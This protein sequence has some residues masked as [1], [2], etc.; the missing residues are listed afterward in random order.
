MSGRLVFVMHAHLPYVLGQGEWPHG[1]AWL[2]EAAVD[3]Y[4]PLLLALEGLAA[5]EVR[6]ALTLEFSPVLGEQLDDERFRAGCRRHLDAL[7]AAADRNRDDPDPEVAALATG[8]S[9]HY[10]RLRDEFERRDGRLLDGFRQLDETGAIELFTCARSH[11]FLPL[12]GSAPRVERQVS[13]GVAWFTQRFGR[14]P[15]GIWMP[16]CAYRPGLEEVLEAAGLRWTIVDAHL[17]TGGRPIGNYP[18]WSAATSPGPSPHEVYQIGRSSVAAFAR[19]PTTT[20]QVWSGDAGYP[21]DPWFLEFHKKHHDGGVRYWRVTDRALDLGDKPPYDPG[22]A[23]TAVRNQ[24]LH[25]ANLVGETIASSRRAGVA[26]PVVLAPYDAELFGH[27]WREG[28]D[29]YM[30]AR[31]EL[32]AARIDVVTASE[33]LAGATPRSMTL[34]AGSWGDG[35]DYRVW[36]QPATASMWERVHQAEQWLDAVE[37]A[38]FL[39]PEADAVRDQLRRTVLLVESSDWQFLRSTGTAA[40]YAEARVASHFSDAHRLWGMW[41][42]L[43]SGAGLSA[44]ETGTL[45]AMQDRDR[46]WLP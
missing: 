25:F 28:V 5:D 17:V 24:G 3:T 7:V 8:T 34:P 14:A 37:A 23:Q 2:Y 45:A 42:R 13:D 27:W 12:L 11:G 21:G 33:A 35:G 26:D 44:T 40:E 29:W 22:Q 41:R 30:A 32:R 1:E 10:Q 4:L 15:A 38:T 16:E 31:R 9:H 6:P 36:S 43:E 39:G 18:P 19:D 20:M 46:V